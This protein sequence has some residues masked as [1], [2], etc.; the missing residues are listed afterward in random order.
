MVLS[1]KTVKIKA[2]AEITEKKSKFIATA[3]PV[4]TEDEA[5]LFIEETKKKYK[6]AT[7][8]CMAYR[9][10]TDTISERRSDDG[11]PPGTAGAPIL[12]VLRKENL[13]NAI[14]IVTRYY[15]GIPLGANGLTRAY[16]SSCAAGINAAGITVKHLMQNMAVTVSYGLSGKFGHEIANRGFL[17]KDVVYGANV[18]FYVSHPLDLAARANALYTQISAGKAVIKELD[19]E[20][21]TQQTLI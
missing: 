6:D 5:W 17:L 16:S 13:I 7:H 15:G 8:N 2:E 12:E 10:G 1:Y 21:L 18:T 4:S 19:K 3:A 11:E 20:Y 9:T 14:V